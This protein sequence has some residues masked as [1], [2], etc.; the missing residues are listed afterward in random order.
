MLRAV[1]SSPSGSPGI[2]EYRG[3]WGL[4]ST[5]NEGVA[6]VVAVVVVRWSPSVPLGYN[7]MLKWPKVR[8]VRRS[9]VQ[10]ENLPG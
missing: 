3:R 5:V 8:Q 1:E 10:V 2:T 6:V 4:Q 7:Y 9:R